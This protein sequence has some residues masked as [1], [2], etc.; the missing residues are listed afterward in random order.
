[1]AH[2][3]VPNRVELRRIKIVL[4]V[5]DPARTTDQLAVVFIILVA[6]AEKSICKRL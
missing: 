3:S 1:M 2:P 4:F 5:I 6:V